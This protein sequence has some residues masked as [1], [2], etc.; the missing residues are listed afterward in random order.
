MSVKSISIK[1]T[2]CKP[3]VCA[4]GGQAY[5]GRSAACPGFGTEGGVIRPDRA[6]EVSRGHSSRGSGEDPNGPPKGLMGVGSG[7]RD[8]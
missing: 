7:R 3:G 6:T 5:L 2:G 4:E 1:G 8:S